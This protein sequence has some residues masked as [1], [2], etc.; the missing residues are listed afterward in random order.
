MAMIFDAAGNLYGATS[1]VTGGAA[2]HGTV[3]ELSLV[4]GVW[5]EN[6]LHSFT[7]GSDGDMPFGAVI[8]RGADL[9]GTTRGGGANGRGT[10]YRIR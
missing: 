2:S 8:C 6:I 5:T 1:A 4:Q 3:F 10:V 9:Y 7:G